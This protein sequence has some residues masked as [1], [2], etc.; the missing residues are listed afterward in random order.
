M[1]DF[2]VEFCVSLR[3]YDEDI[4]KRSFDGSPEGWRKTSK[5]SL[6]VVRGGPA[7]EIEI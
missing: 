4:A 6:S 2:G 1:F 7:L 3:Y 5:S